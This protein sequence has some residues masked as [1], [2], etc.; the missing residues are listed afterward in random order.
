MVSPA[1]QHVPASPQEVTRDSRA[2]YG[3]IERM[4]IGKSLRIRRLTEVKACKHWLNSGD[5]DFEAIPPRPERHVLWCYSCEQFKQPEEFHRNRTQTWRLER[6]TACKVCRKLSKT[7][8][9][10]VWGWYRN[11]SLATRDTSLG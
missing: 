6:H 3:R 8:E 5:S 10:V 2:V 4:R 9:S 7:A 11:P 1:L